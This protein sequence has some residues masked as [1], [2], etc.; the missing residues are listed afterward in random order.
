MVAKLFEENKSNLN[1]S[2]Q[3]LKEVINVK[4]NSNLIQ[5]PMDGNYVTDKY[6]I[7][8]EF[9]WLFVGQI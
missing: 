3:I 4:E 7:A 6:T 2:R 8:N 1:N 9:S 5:I